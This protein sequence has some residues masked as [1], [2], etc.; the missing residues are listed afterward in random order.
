LF[1]EHWLD[2]FNLNIPVFNELQH[3]TSD[4]LGQINQWNFYYSNFN[5]LDEPT[6]DVFAIFPN[7]TDNI[8][9]VETGRGMSLLDQTYHITN[10]IGQALMIGTITAENHRID[11]SDLPQ[12]MYFITVG[13]AT[14]KFVV[15]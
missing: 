11:V 9:D 15:R 13:D 1:W 3:V 5:G 12:G 6:E 7:P 4:N 2:D 8:L 14:R 10:M